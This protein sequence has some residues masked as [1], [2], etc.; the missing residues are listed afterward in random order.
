MTAAV[1]V[2]G[3]KSLLIVESPTDH[4]LHCPS[5]SLANLL[6]GGGEKPSRSSG[7]AENHYLR[8]RA[9]LSP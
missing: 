8:L 2:M 6:V 4:S 9:V 7:I 1:E 3:G 5:F